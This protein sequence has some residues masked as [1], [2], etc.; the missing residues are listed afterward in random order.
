MGIRKEDLSFG[1]VNC[2]NYLHLPTYLK[3]L[4]TYRKTENP[5]YKAAN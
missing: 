2:G 5:I 4:P 1:E 3:D